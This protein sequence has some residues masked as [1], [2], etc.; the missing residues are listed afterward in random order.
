MEMSAKR[1]QELN[2]LLAQLFGMD[3]FISPEQNDL[4]PVFVESEPVVEAPKQ[5]NYPGFTGKRFT[6]LQSKIDALN[7]T[8]ESKESDVD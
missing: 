6:S 1:R 2:Y 5:I 4:D 7:A 3:S 8:K